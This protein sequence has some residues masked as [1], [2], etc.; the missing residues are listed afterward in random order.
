ME[1]IQKFRLLNHTSKLHVL[2]PRAR[3]PPSRQT[4]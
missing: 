3:L 2:V 1:Y 4:G